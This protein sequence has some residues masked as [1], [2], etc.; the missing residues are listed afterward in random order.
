MFFF[1]VAG[2]LT[3]PNPPTVLLFI[4]MVTLDGYI[5]RFF[6][7]KKEKP[8]PQYFFETSMSSIIILKN[9]CLLIL[10]RDPSVSSVSLESIQIAFLLHSSWRFSFDV[11]GN[12]SN[13]RSRIVFSLGWGRK[14]TNGRVKLIVREIAF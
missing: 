8:C 3:V 5:I 6:K 14:F 4:L 10:F 12:S 13:Y 7:K 1:K 11:F 9:F 2:W